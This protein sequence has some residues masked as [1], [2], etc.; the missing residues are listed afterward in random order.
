MFSR[1]VSFTAV[2]SFAPILRN[3]SIRM[4][5]SARV[6][7]DEC[8]LKKGELYQFTDTGMHGICSLWIGVRYIDLIKGD[9]PK[10]KKGTMVELYNL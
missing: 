2:K 1:L 10:C 9:G 3:T 8:I 5:A 4:I 7:A 6:G